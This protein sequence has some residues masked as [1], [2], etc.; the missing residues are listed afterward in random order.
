MW[1]MD[2]ASLTQS[3]Q[4]TGATLIATR[5]WEGWTSRR[6]L[7]ESRWM[8][9]TIWT[10]S[11][12]GQQEMW[13]I[14]RTIWKK[15]LLGPE[16]VALTELTRWRGRSPDREGPRNIQ[17]GILTETEVAEGMTRVLAE[18]GRGVPMRWQRGTRRRRYP[19]RGQTRMEVVEDDEARMMR[20]G[21]TKIPAVPRRTS[22]Q[23]EQTE[24]SDRGERARRRF[25]KDLATKTVYDVRGNLQSTQSDI[26]TKRAEAEGEVP[27]M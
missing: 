9:C 8:P 11:R 14:P 6:S 21:I 5:R 4:Q 23:R 27:R 12:R 20:R 10:G 16:G 3:V 19:R 25:Q 26:W 24:I 7:R 17:T 13:T 2:L 15:S 22:M 1:L 18:V